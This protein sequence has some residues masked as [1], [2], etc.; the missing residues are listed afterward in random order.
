MLRF[1]IC[2]SLLYI[3]FAFAGWVKLSFW[4]GI[5][6]I[7]SIFQVILGPYHFKFSTLMSTSECLFRSMQDNL[8]PII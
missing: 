3:G 4:N 5:K 2:A 1:L 6:E 7:R 8:Y